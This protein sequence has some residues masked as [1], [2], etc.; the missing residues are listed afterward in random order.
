MNVTSCRSLAAIAR[1]PAITLAR[2]GARVGA[3]HRIAI[4]ITEAPAAM[5]QPA[6]RSRICDAG[7]GSETGRMN[8]SSNDVVA[9][10]RTELITAE[11]K[12]TNATRAI[13]A[14]A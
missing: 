1:Q 10:A 11:N 9:P 3:G 4:A 8:A 12:T 7:P 14:T 6:T 5:P 2:I 13:P